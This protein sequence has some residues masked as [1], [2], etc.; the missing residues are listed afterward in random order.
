[1]DKHLQVRI[2]IIDQF[3]RN[4]QEQLCNHFKVVS[5]MTE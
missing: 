5:K 1:M 4:R 3:L 2:V